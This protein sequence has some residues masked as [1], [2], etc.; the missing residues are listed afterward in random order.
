MQR[1]VGQLV[2]LPAILTR[3]ADGVGH[4]GK[5]RWMTSGCEKSPSFIFCLIQRQP[6]VGQKLILVD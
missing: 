4:L 6:G 2:D 3:R 1:A 5:N